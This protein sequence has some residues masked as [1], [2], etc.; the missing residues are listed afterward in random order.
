M[1]VRD[2][3]YDAKQ[4][5]GACDDATLYNRLSYAIEVLANKGQWDAMTAYMDIVVQSGNVVVLPREVEMPL[6][7]NINTQPSFMRSRMYE[8]AMDGPGNDMAETVGFSWMEKGETPMLQQ[9]PTPSQIKIDGMSTMDNGK[10][11]TIVG[12]DADNIEVT[13]TFVLNTLAPPVTNTAYKDI[14]RVVKDVTVSNVKLWDTAFNLIGNY[15]PD[16]TEPMYRKI[17]LTKTAPAIRMLFRRRTYAV[18]SDDDFIPLNSAMAVLM[19]LKSLEMYRSGGGDQ[20][21]KAGPLE[22]VALKFLKEEQDSRNAFDIAKNTE[23]PPALDLNYNNSDS[24]IVADLYDDAVN[25]F[26]NV[27]RQNIFDRMTETIEILNNKGNWDGLTGYVDIMTDNFHLVTL[28]R[29]VETPIAINVNG[30]PKQMRNK[31]FE[32]HLN[33][34]GSMSQSC[35]MWDDVDEVYMLRPLSVISQFYAQPDLAGDDGKTITIYGYDEN[36]K[37]IRTQVGGVWQDGFVVTLDHLGTPPDTNA[38]KCSRVVRITRD[39]TV[40]FVRLMSYDATTQI[41]ITQGYYYPDETEP[42][43]RRIRVPYAGAW[44][45]MRYRKRTLK[46]TSLTDQIM[47]KSKISVVLMMKSLAAILDPQPDFEKAKQFHD[48]SVLALVEEQ[49]SRN[50]AETFDI[51]FANIPCHQVII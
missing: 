39:A 2:I 3:K 45:R 11:V 13:E 42:R 30:R 34:P 7:I 21:Q 36:L 19:M 17:V 20:L 38:Q 8:F 29:D 28:P 47:L 25:I 44:V 10:S 51:Q 27:G 4:V 43:Y 18:K 37:W 49:A 14:I 15:L 33:G 12:R 6:K 48:A 31:W 22:E 24:I 9:P 35:D 1:L 40:G 16:D 5:I 32:F 50:P 26:G 46:I 23:T 41:S